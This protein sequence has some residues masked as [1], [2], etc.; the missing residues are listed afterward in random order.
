MA[1]KD[2][3]KPGKEYHVETPQIN[4]PFFLKGS[5]ALDWGMQNRLAQ[6]FNSESNIN[7][8]EILTF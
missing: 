1:D 4:N 6:I 2:D 3:L 8:F 5:G 7:T